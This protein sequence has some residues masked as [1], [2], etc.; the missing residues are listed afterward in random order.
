MESRAKLFG[1]PA[2][3]ILVAF[4]VGLLVTGLFFDIAY[5]ITKNSQFAV[6]AYWM[7]AS[8]VI[9]GLV[10]AVFGA[11]DLLAI[12]NN[13]RAKM[14]GLWHGVINVAAMLLFAISWWLR[15]P[16]PEA[17]NWAAIVLSFIGVGQ[18]LITGWLGGELVHR[19]NVGNDAGANVNAP[20][21]LSGLPANATVD[22]METRK[23]DSASHSDRSGTTPHPT[24]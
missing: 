12:P 3:T 21:S 4:P 24:G 19:L 13:T 5:L 20:S 22:Y 6:V 2:H 18:L 15:S 1:H 14:I 23:G 9:G 7:V 10:A 8:G 11:V 16:Q 17:P